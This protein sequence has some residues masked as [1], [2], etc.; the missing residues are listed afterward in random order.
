MRLVL[1]SIVLWGLSAGGCGGGREAEGPGPLEAEQYGG[2]PGLKEVSDKGLREELARIVEEGGTPELLTG[3][4]AIAEQ[5]N[6]AAGL[7]GLF[8]E[9]EIDSILEESEKV[10]PPGRFELDAIRLRQAVTFRKEHEAQRLGARAALGRP[11]CDFGI[12]FT[13]GL[14]GQWT[15]I[16]VVRIC[17]RL[18]AFR[19]AEMLADGRVDEAIEC[20]GMMLR[21]AWCLGAETHAMARLEAAFLRTEAFGLLQAIVQHDQV[22]RGHLDRLYGMVEGQLASWPDDADAW[23]GDRALGLHTYE[24]VRAGRLKELLEEEEI[25]QFEKEGALEDV[26]AA[27][28]RGVDGDELY[29]L[30]T[31]R[32]IVGSCS[33]PYYARLPLLEAIGSELQQRRSSPDFP[34]VAARVLVLGEV[35]KGHAIQAQDRANWEAW[36]LALALATGREMPAYRVNPLTGQEYS[37]ERRD[38]VIE[39]A[40]FGSG[41]EGDHPWI[42]VPDLGGGD[43][44]G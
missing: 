28:E 43:Q 35:R 14:Q 40:N 44:T 23:I 26:L 7:V 39:V 6:V 24:V 29:Y 27:A 42:V 5:D 21:L 3:R 8:P 20:L 30:Q 22:V 10:F 18:E 15:F 31:M 25:R 41:E 13:A 17:G 2:L 1:A 11:E 12:R 34:L 4:R 19:A 33:R 32:K 9:E 36:A 37:H 16:D 38:Q